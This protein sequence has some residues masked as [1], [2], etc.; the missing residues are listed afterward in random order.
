LVAGFFPAATPRSTVTTDG[1]KQVRV[2]D[3][4]CASTPGMSDSRTSHL[5]PLKNSYGGGD[6]NPTGAAIYEAKLVAAAK[7][8]RATRKSQAPRINTVNAQA[9]RTCPRC[10]RTFRARIGLVVHLRTQCN[11]NPIQSTSVK[12]TPDPTTVTPTTPTTNNNFIDALP[13]MIADTILPLL[14]A[15]ITATNTTCPTPTTSVA[16]SNYLL[17]PTPPPNLLP[18]N[19][20]SEADALAVVREPTL[21]TQ[22]PGLAPPFLRSE[23]NTQDFFQAAWDRHVSH[24]REATR[25]SILASLVYPPST[26]DGASASIAATGPTRR[27]SSRASVVLSPVRQSCIDGV[28][29]DSNSESVVTPPKNT[30]GNAKDI[31]YADSVSQGVITLAM[32]DQTQKRQPRVGMVTNPRSFSRF[33]LP[34]KYILFGRQRSELGLSDGILPQELKQLNESSTKES[35]NS[36]VNNTDPLAVPQALKEPVDSLQEPPK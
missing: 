19:V 15:P 31:D 34:S 28:S 2:S 30:S 10:Q 36:V 35:M 24:L 18:V 23:A 22:P 4:V 26:G 21:P 14:P 20:T 16:T 9:L 3:A 8:K 29:F 33:S 17:P 12:P 13:P 32:D 11:K 5:P 25:A 7:S 6:S 27:S 1:L